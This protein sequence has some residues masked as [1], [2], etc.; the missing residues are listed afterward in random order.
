MTEKEKMLAGMIY[1]AN[2]DKDLMQERLQ[3]KDLCYA[4]N[5]LRP[6]QIG[7]QTQL[8]RE[9]FGKTKK[10]FYVLSP[11]W[12]D[13][14][15]NIEIGENFFM[16]HNCV[17]LDCAKVTFGDNVFIA[18]DCGFYTAG[19]PMDAERRNQGLEYARPI[20]V[21]DNV[22]IGAGVQ[23]MPGVTIGNDTVIAGGS[24][25]TKDIPDHVL[26]GGNP[27]RIIRP[28]P[29]KFCEGDLE[30]VMEI[31][32][33]WAI[34]AQPEHTVTLRRAFEELYPKADISFFATDEASGELISAC[35]SAN[36]VILCLGEDQSRTGEGKSV[37]DTS[38]SASHK[39]LFETVANV[40]QNTV[41]L[42]FG[43]RPLCVPELDK[44][45]AAVVEAWLPGTC[46]T[47]AVADIIFGRVNPS[48]RVP[49]SFPYCPGQ[50][51]MCYC[52]L[53]TGRPKPNEDRYYP[54]VSNYMDV[55]NKPLYS[56]GHGLSYTK[57]EYS[58]VELSGYILER[59]KTITASV[60][61]TNTGDMD[62]AEPV[63]LYIRDLAGSVSR[64]VKQLKGVKKLTIKS[65]E[66]ARVSFEIDEDMLKFYDI[67]M[68]FTAEPG[69]FQLW[70]GGSSETDNCAYFELR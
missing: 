50:L 14:G 37:A 49:M 7:E 48:A 23:V 27:C 20:T 62:G 53:P 54:F 24:I 46:G 36:A 69:K 40:N 29:Q 44:C 4:F 56:F 55:P 67:D 35:A 9:I 1:D 39:R 58:K 19:H 38:L 52:E 30:Q 66:S 13:Y 16:N 34:F 51:P 15:Y 42:L 25:V 5:Q 68:N 11:F 31:Y 65:G 59:G 2:Y 47:Y 41:A 60:T 6:S 21:G 61:V 3:C 57:F 70:I 18:P 43:G 63:Q 17:I 26:A 33:S 64:P 45:C 32:G 22:W 8:I 28:L 10:S 12:C